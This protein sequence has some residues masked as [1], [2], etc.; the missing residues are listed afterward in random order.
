MINARQ[1]D[2]QFRRGVV[3]GLTMA[4][5]LL[6]LIFVLLLILA[7]RLVDEKAIAAT[8]TDTVATLRARLAVAQ[9][10]LDGNFDIT[11]EYVRIEEELT[12]ARQDLA[13]TEHRLTEAEK[14]TA[15]MAEAAALGREIMDE[16]QAIDPA[17]GPDALETL[18]SEA[19]TG[20]AVIAQAESLNPEATPEEAL[21]DLMRDAAAG[22]QSQ[23]DIASAADAM[24]QLES[25]QSTL[26]NCKGQTAYLNGQLGRAGFG[27]PPCWVSPEGRIEYIFAARLTDQGIILID[28]ALPHRAKQQAE[29]PLDG[30]RFGVP[31]EAGSFRRAVSDL[32]AWS[33]VNECRFVVDFYD[34]TGHDKN[35]FKTLQHAVEANFFIRE[36]G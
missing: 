17:A 18:I 36:R 2:R 26:Q 25:C 4:E 27:E 1:D 3:L 5:I 33:V 6:L 30:I 24:A 19:K 31:L 11:K 10:Q 9:Q 35:H 20:R 7:A 22:R 21:Q 28:Y 16:I 13:E 32:F 12:A 14:A 15:E 34:E 29:L 23:A 8:A